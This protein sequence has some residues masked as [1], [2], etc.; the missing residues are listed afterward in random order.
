MPEDSEN[1][2][3]VWELEN[4]DPET[5]HP[6][7]IEKEVRRLQVV[8]SYHLLD[9]KP[10]DSYQ[11]LVDLAADLFDVKFCI[12]NL[13]DLGRYYLLAQH[14]F[15]TNVKEMMKTKSMPMPHRI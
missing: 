8:K 12:I 9:T 10:D 3:L 14:G 2:K 7:D 4:Y 11:R 15:P 1:T 5:T 13:I 6:P